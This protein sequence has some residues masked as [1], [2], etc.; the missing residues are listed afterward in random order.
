M[1]RSVGTRKFR[2]LERVSAKLYWC[3]QCN[4]PLLTRH[5]GI[6]GGEGRPLRLTPPADARPA[7][8]VE[9]RQLWELIEEETG[10]RG[11]YPK[12]KVVLLNKIPYPDAADEVVVDGYVIGHRYYDLSTGRWRFKPLYA[13]VSEILRRREGFYAVVN[14][15][16]LARNYEIHRDKVVEANLPPK[17]SRRYI[18]LGTTTGYEGVGMLIRG[19][20][21][22]VL[23]CWRA[24]RYRWGSKDPSWAEVVKANEARLSLLEQEAIEFLRRVH[25]KHGLPPV[26]SFSGG[27]DSL[28]TYHIAKKALG[29]VAILFND[30]GL[31]LPET[32]S[33][34][35]QFA[36]REGVELI[37][38]DAG[39]AFWSSLRTMG[40]PAR[41][42]RWCCK[43]VKL[44]P[45][46]KT[47]QERFKGGALSIVGQRRLESASR[48]LSPRV[49][50]NRWLPNVVV[51]AP[52][53][54]W[55]ALE[56]WLY[57]LRERLTPNPLYYL[58]F[59]RLG[60]WLCPAMEVGEMEA[61]KAIH[62][63]LWSRWEEYLESYA[64]A[65]SLPSE[66]LTLALWRWLIPP[67][68]VRRLLRE[69]E[70][71]LSALERGVRVK[72]WERAGGVAVR[73][74]APLH[75][76]DARSIAN[77][78]TALAEVLVLDDKSLEVGGARVHIRSVENGVEVELRGKLEAEA[79]LKS[80][81]RAA[82]CIGCGSCELWCP[83][84]ALRLEG[85]VP[86]VELQRCAHC[87]VCNRVCP[88]AEYTAKL[89]RLRSLQ[90]Q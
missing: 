56:V 82:F 84:E 86:L 11:L 13:G 85:G 19:G 76:M 7:F 17:G 58:G 71:A 63:D 8:G 25:E 27:K 37:V 68:D 24:K 1:A 40:P 44:V 57:I 12:R 15:P 3:E 73:V 61:V 83:E 69:Q 80:V 32:L 90:A 47:I 2:V 23:K 9:Y 18:A 28:V 34:V 43:V 52:I 35:K 41:D 72:V 65:R 89:M 48:A 4:L 53:A 21:I 78:L 45:I 70:A 67:G 74:E 10:V 79:L 29:K 38:A 66:W 64:K 31:E 81:V 30:T 36:K 22:R 55:T 42:Y 16:S 87:G 75:P 51:A 26:V 50:R 20:R 88:V 33:Y 5:C 6:C 14:L 62:P 54:S 39:L 46:A 59:D 77:T 49:Y 60:C